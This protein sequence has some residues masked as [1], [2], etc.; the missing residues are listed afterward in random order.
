MKKLAMIGGG[1]ALATAAAFAAG[2]T[3]LVTETFMIP[4]ADAGLQLHVRNMRPAGVSRFPAER[5]VLFVHGATY[6]AEMIGEGT[7]SVML[8][9]NRLHLIRQVQGFLDD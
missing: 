9:K 1:L 6:P 7:H 5:I 3:N 8:E 2:K 4:A